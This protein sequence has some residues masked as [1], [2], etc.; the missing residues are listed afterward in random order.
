MKK[1]YLFLTIL[2]SAVML[3]GCGDT[4]GKSVATVQEI[5]IETVAQSTEDTQ[6]DEVFSM[7]EE[8]TAAFEDITVEV[9]G[10]KGSILVGTIGAPF[11]ELLTQARIM[12]AKEGRD[13]QIKYYEDSAQLTADVLSGVL[14]AH[15]FAHQTYVDSYNDV[16]K[17]ELVCVTPVCYEVYGIYSKL[18]TDL[19]KI[20]GA[21]VALPQEAEK[22]ARALL[23]L[24][25]LNWITLNDNAGMTAILE[26][27]V[28]NDKNLQFTEFTQETLETVTEESDYCIVGAD[29]AI[30]CGL[31]VQDDSIRTETSNSISAQIF[32]TVLVTTPEKAEDENVQAL[33]KALV[34]EEMTTYVQDTYKGALQLMK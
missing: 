29:T 16:N 20:S 27:I 34:S 23:F 18:N 24:Q 11:T 33:A 9:N 7:P 15:L 26:D 25:D 17:T 31:D 30:V 8:E 4:Q 32:A 10:D 5:P 21:T 1:R 14:D 28:S 22:K 13:V 3:S 12:L 6:E 19:T 2:L